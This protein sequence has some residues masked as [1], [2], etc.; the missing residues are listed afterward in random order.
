LETPISDGREINS[1]VGEVAEA[2]FF[3]VPEE[4]VFIRDFE[5]GA[6]QTVV[7]AI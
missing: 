7:P 3:I 2:H 6:K 4:A 1:G 5:G